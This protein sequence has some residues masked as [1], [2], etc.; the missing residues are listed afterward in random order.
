MK[1]IAQTFI[2]TGFFVFYALSA[3]AQNPET[4]LA[5]D[6]ASALQR[7]QCCD[8]IS[9]KSASVIG[10]KQLKL[11]TMFSAQEGSWPFEPFANN[12]LFAVIARYQKNHPKIVTLV[13]GRYTLADIARELKRRDIL[14]PLD[15][16]YVLHY[17]IMVMPGAELLIEKTTL[18]LS[19][20]SG[21]AIINQGYVNIQ[22]ASVT[23][24]QGDYPKASV[25]NYRPFMI[26]WGGS[27][28]EIADSTLAKL[29][30]DAYLSTGV[31]ATISKHQVSGTLAPQVSVRNS[32]FSDATIGLDLTATHAV[33][34]NTSFNAS[35]HHAVNIDSSQ[36]AIRDTQFN[37]SSVNSLLRVTG[38]S[39][40]EVANSRLEG[41]AKHAVEW[42][43]TAGSLLLRDN[44]F[45][46]SSAHGLA[47]KEDNAEKTGKEVLLVS[48]NN[49]FSEN[50]GAGVNIEKSVSAI[51]ADTDFNGNGSYA[52]SYRSQASQGN[53]ELLLYGNRFINLSAPAI[54]TEHVHRVVLHENDFQFSQMHQGVFAGELAPYQTALAI[55]LFRDRCLTTVEREPDAFTLRVST[56]S[57]KAGSSPGACIR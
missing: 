22:N 35:R 42:S 6:I 12:G 19:I 3:S 43:A 46:R 32:V 9:L 57:A 13:S 51:V 33:I 11:Q 37:G 14:E 5:D 53:G 40:V 18:Y 44:Q 10:P 15:D 50:A 47:I 7:A 39:R 16:G 21:S 26:S 8:P 4:A 31:A 30:Y 41:S 34:E 55:A 52:I 24:R 17:P 1:W 48:A 54:R 29:G 28:L 27:T 45:T 2:C 56:G 36:V 38:I 49:Q 20:Y 25:E 23:V